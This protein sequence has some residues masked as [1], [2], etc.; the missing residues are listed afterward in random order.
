MVW[1]LYDGNHPERL[2]FIFY[3]NI[4][5]YKGVLYR[6]TMKNSSKSKGWIF[7]IVGL[8]FILSGFIL[9][10]WFLAALFSSDGII[11][12]THKI[13]IWLVDICLISTGLIVIKLR[14]SLTKEMLFV[15]TGVFIIFAGI[16]FIEK[17]L[18]MALNTPMTDY[19][20]PFLRA[21]E[22]YFIATGLFAILYRRA[23]DLKSISRFGISS[24]ICLA[25]FSLYVFYRRGV[26]YNGLIVIGSLLSIN[27]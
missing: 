27:F 13:V 4:K 10:E 22:V 24:L 21:F 5:T 14:R 12:T 19:N 6:V 18:P 17:F 1:L 8:L 15:F 11:A 26:L 2:N 16:L 20:R 23:I 7:I 3:N 9:N 25:L